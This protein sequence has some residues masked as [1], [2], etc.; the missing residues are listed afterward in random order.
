M[1][2]FS[3]CHAIGLTCGVPFGGW[4]L[5]ELGPQFL[6]PGCFACAMLAAGLYVLIYWRQPLVV[7]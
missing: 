3:L 5:E 1:G 2:I 7:D 4:V 6:W